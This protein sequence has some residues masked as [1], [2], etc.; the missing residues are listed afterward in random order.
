MNQQ[1]LLF[2]WDGLTNSYH[3]W[4]EHGN[5]AKQLLAAAELLWKM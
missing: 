2:C 5:Y 3:Y 1:L 4:N